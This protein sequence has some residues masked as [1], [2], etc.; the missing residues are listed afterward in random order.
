MIF[1]VD[2]INMQF[3]RRIIFK[4]RARVK[5]FLSAKRHLSFSQNIYNVCFSSF[6][7]LQILPLRKEIDELKEELSNFKCESHDT[8]QEA[9]QYC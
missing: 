3:R 7:N 4:V 8:R 9:S 5:A 1:E 6:Y 2:F